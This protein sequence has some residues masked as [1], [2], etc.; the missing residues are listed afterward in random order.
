MFHVKEENTE[1]QL[2]YELGSGMWNIPKLR[3]LLEEIIPKNSQFY[4]FEVIHEFPVI[5]KKVLALNARKVI[6]K[7]HDQQLILLAIE[8]ITQQSAAKKIIAEREAWFHH[9]A[10]NAPVLVWVTDAN[11]QHSIL[12][13]TWLEFTGRTFEKNHEMDWTEII[14]PSE[15]ERF[16]KLYKKNFDKRSTFEME[17]RIRR[18]D[19]VYR[20]VHCNGKPIYD[21][22]DTFT[23]YFGTCYEIHDSRVINE[24]LEARVIDRTMAL[25]IVN[26]NLERSNDELQ[27]F[28]YVASH[29]LQEPLRKI[30]TFVDRMNN[31]S[32]NKLPSDVKKYLEKI[33]TSSF[34]MKKLIEDLLSFSRVYRAPESFVKMSLRDI[35]KDVIKDFDEHIR[36]DAAII[37]LGKLP[38]LEVVPLQM[39]QLFHNLISNALKFKSNSRKPLI[40]LSSRRIPRREMKKHP[41]LDPTKSYIELLVRDNGIGFKKEFADQIFVI[42]QRL[43]D[44]A[45]FE[46]TGI[47]LALCRKIASNHGGEIF[48]ESKEHHGSVFHV[49]LPVKQER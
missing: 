28:A 47:G 38:V 23:G 26:A 4:G 18:Y 35:L 7:S 45:R 2:V 24:E 31:F 27:Q 13:K 48:A 6:R 5:G 33:T 17:F 41:D 44:K 25:N 46:G 34:R 20:W 40:N 10:D 32:D 49:I 16:L 37:T 21:L 1:G 14:H 19:G 36:S 43:H 12:N 3:E 9:I 11:R 8:D 30:I 42:F 39:K 15:L 22:D 29:D